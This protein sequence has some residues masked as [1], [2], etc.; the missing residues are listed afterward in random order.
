MP[1]A[2]LADLDRAELA[3]ARR[4]CA[5]ARLDLVVGRLAAPER[6]GGLVFEQLYTEAG[7]RGGRPRASAAGGAGGACRPIR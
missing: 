3:A 4:S 1:D 2:T 5:R 6:D 7:G